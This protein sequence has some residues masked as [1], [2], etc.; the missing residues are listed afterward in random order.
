MSGIC[1]PQSSIVVLEVV[2]GYKQE[3]R[4]DICMTQWHKFQL[5]CWR[6]SHEGNEIWRGKRKSWSKDFVRCKRMDKKIKSSSKIGNVL[7]PFLFD[8]EILTF[9]NRKTNLRLGDIWM[10]I[11]VT[12]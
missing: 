8:F 3:V 11:A 10:L 12:S 5:S 1:W 6:Q 7:D 2:L 9:E 4:V